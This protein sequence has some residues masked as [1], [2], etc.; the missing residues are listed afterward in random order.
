MKGKSGA[1]RRHAQMHFPPLEAAEALVFVEIL[2]RAIPA[3]WRS[4]GD[5]MVQELFEHEEQ[6]EMD[7][8]FELEAAEALEEQAAEEWERWKASVGF[9]DADNELF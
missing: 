4:H 9:D 2:E 7:R 3:I 6:A 1:R 5:E 8:Q